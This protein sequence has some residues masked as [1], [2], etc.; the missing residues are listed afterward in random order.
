MVVMDNAHLAAGLKQAGLDRLVPYIQKLTQNSIRLHATAVD[1]TALTVGTARI[2][3]LPDL[4]AALSW[5]QQQGKPLS[6]I[7]Q[8][9]LAELRSYD[10]DHL[11]PAAGMLWFFYDASQQTFGENPGD[12]S[13][14]TV[15]FSQD[16][17]KLQ[18]VPAPASLPKTSLFKA[19]SLRYTNELTFTQQPQLEIPSLPWT[20]QDQQKYEQFLA[21]VSASTGTDPDPFKHR[22]LGYPD[23]LQDDMRLQCE[24]VTHGVQDENDPRIATYQK[25]AAQWH[26]LLQID[27]DEQ[28]GMRWSSNGMLYY[29]ITRS[30]LQT[31]HFAQTWLVLQ[32][33]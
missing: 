31:C 14:W 22:L 17:T 32:A 29:W 4:P 15:L 25:S 16:L 27:S 33:E 6:F 2:G 12:S 30:A 20:T 24:L 26:L 28:A 7:A 11:L 10:T 5:P 19:C 13:G 1:E 8:L 21:T 18:R 9:Q 3:G 23:T